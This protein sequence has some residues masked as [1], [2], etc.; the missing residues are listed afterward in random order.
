MEPRRRFRF[1]KELSEGAFGKVYLAEMITGDNF[2][3]VVAIKLLHGKWTTH[4]EI[5]QRSRD[6]A[7]V[8]GLLHHR[9]IIRVEDLTAI[10]GQ[11]A[12]VMEYLDGVDIK[13]LVN[14]ARDR[15]SRIP[16]KVVFEVGSQIA[17]ALDAAY[18]KQP[19]QGGE[20]LR[21]I[22]RD[23]KPSNV[24]LTVAGDVK[25]LD[26]G[27]AQA[28]FDDR[29]AHTQALAFGSAAYMAPERLLGDPDNP[30]GDVFSLGITLYEMLAL[31]GYGKIHI[32]EERFDA[33]L[34]KR[35]S[36]L[37]LSDLGDE[38]SEQVRMTMGLMLGYDPE[39]RPSAGEV[40]ELLEALAEEVHDGSIRRFCREVVR[41]IR[42]NWS[43]TQDPNDPYT[44][45]TVFE[46]SSGFT[47]REDALGNTPSLTGPA[48]PGE[49]LPAASLPPAPPV[50]GVADPGFSV[51]YGGQRA[52]PSP[53]V[54]GAASPPPPPVGVTTASAA[55]DG[56]EIAPVVPD[57][58]GAGGLPPVGVP[59]PN[60]F[61]APTVHHDPGDIPSDLLGGAR[62]SSQPTH[63]PVAS[64]G[65][66]LRPGQS[67][68]GGGSEPSLP[69]AHSLPGQ[70]VSSQTGPAARSRPTLSSTPMRPAP[71]ARP[72]PAVSPAP[73]QK[74]STNSSARKAPAPR[75]PPP[76]SSGGSGGL[77]KIIAVMVVLIILAG[78]GVGAVIGLGLLDDMKEGKDGATATSGSAPTDEGRG[79]GRVEVGPVSAS[80]G[81]VV[82][83]VRP[84]GKSTVRIS[85]VTGDFKETWNGGGALELIGL[86]AGTY[87]T[88][89][90]PRG[91][92]AVRA[93]FDV[94]AGELCELT[95]DT[96]NN[97]EWNV[98][99][100][101]AAE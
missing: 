67:S 16:R 37:D 90:S 41:P 7:R 69:V 14:N 3:S 91:G 68:F 17:S 13:T 64:S 35:L 20:P 48:D 85:A 49:A 10:Q 39:N 95:F 15:S 79:P 40:T 78:G 23:I 65:P 29:E 59:L 82:L 70:R 26:F 61:T 76:K 53:A 27:T 18:N 92:A 77:G 62:Q 87:R 54:Q 50:A 6:E 66:A 97:A 100:C 51:P 63:R 60:L 1:I 9:N 36:E 4:Q 75:T 89:I 99:N 44:G 88:K 74:P 31:D 2:K 98:G 57:P 83:R 86:D 56:I 58:G 34:E 47:V 12:I 5:V 30:S 43:P 81:T 21:L 80:T 84:P 73:G 55:G 11:C 93:T 72:K 28:R 45:T 25:V 19:L 8:L 46:D 96:K 94:K 101:A 38:R 33:K 42:E 71:A 24:M 22:H 52:A 32:R